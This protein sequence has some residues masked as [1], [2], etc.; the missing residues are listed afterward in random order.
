MEQAGLKMTAIVLFLISIGQAAAQPPQTAQP[1]TLI[2]FH[3]EYKMKHENHR[4]P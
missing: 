3:H 4:Q 1:Y 2:K